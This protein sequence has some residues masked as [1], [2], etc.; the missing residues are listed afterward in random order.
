[1]VGNVEVNNLKSVMDVRLSFTPLAMS[2]RE[3][4]LP[5]AVA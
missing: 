1:M 4:S 3:L 2:S 5:I